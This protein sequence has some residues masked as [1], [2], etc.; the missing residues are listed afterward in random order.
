MGKVIAIL[1][2]A[3]LTGC[4]S[5]KPSKPAVIDYGAAP[6][7]TGTVQRAAVCIG[8][9]STM[10]VYGGKSLLCP[11]ADVD[12]YLAA[13]RCRE[14]GIT[15]VT[16]LLSFHATWG[17]VYHAI[18]A[19]VKDFD[20]PE[21]LL[22]ITL[23]GHGTRIPD[24]SGDES[25]GYDSG[26]CLADGTRCDDLVWLAILEL[27]PCRIFFPPDTCFSDQSWRAHIPFAGI[28]PPI[29]TVGPRAGEWGGTI[30]SPA[31][32]RKYE[33][34]L[35]ASEGGQWTLALFDETWGHTETYQAWFD[36]AAP[37]VDGQTPTMS[38]Y[39]HPDAI[40]W[41]LNRKPLE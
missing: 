11:G 30:V 27:D 36:M 14:A 20:G 28:E 9:L 18:K 23:S 15:N 3:I 8:V 12:M 32:S 29:V 4:A 17:G 22:V 35:G 1:C 25:D 26:W 41:F 16:E 31:S 7:L 24:Y 19:A 13:Q 37:L 34:S 38:T 33:S 5:S 2:A 6:A 40:R 21:D 39:G 10:S